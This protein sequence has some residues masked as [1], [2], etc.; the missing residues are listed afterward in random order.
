[1]W[2]VIHLTPTANGQTHVRAVGMGFTD[3]PE[4]AR[5]RAFF[6]KGNDDTLDKLRER[7]AR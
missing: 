2:T 3:E 1:M 6:Q 5:M 4:S 7:F